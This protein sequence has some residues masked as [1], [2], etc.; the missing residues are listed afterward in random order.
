MRLRLIAPA[1]T[2]ATLA[3]PA[4]A[5]DAF[6]PATAVE[7]FLTDAATLGATEATVGE[8]SETDGTVTASDVAM[9]WTT[10]LGEGDAALTFNVSVTIPSVEVTGLDQT[11]EGYSVGEL[12]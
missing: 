6:D 11:A 1:L 7:E 5:Q 8:V 10:T 3:G 2:L 12:N 4:L 9:T